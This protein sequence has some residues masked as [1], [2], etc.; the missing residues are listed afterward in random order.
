M[1]NSK[2]LAIPLLAVLVVSSCATAPSQNYTPV[3]YV[4]E[5]SRFPANENTCWESMKR[6]L[7]PKKK[8]TTVVDGST[9]S[10]GSK[11]ITADT[12]KSPTRYPKGFED[13]P[14][15]HIQYGFESEY[16]HDETEVL[17]KSYMPAPPFYTGTKEEWLKLSPEQR[18]QTFD[19]IIAK[20][21]NEKDPPSNFLP[22]EQKEN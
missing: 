16:L 6:F 2:K 9:V 22:T 10:V 12:A 20:T 15:A 21:R 3:A 19:D 1:K 13:V 14:G 18:L 8:A 4:D 17:L 5:L 7:Y 11:K